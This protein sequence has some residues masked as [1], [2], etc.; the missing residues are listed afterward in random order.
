[1]FYIETSAKTGD[2]VKNMFMLIINEL[3]KRHGFPEYKKESREPK[4]NI[5]RPPEKTVAVAV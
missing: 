2:N 5:S 3:I 1:M 4:I